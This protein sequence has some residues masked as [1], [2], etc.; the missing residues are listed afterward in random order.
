MAP[1]FFM[2]ACLRYPTEDYHVD[3]MNL[4]YF[5]LAENLEEAKISVRL[6]LDSS[7]HLVDMILSEEDSLSVEY[8]G[9]SYILDEEDSTILVMTDVSYTTTIPYSDPT[10]P[11]TL[12]F[13]RPDGQYKSE[14]YLTNDF[15][16]SVE[17]DESFTFS[18]SRSMPLD[19]R[20]TPIQNVS[21]VYIGLRD[22]DCAG[23]LSGSVENTGQSQIEVSLDEPVIHTGAIDLLCTVKVYVSGY[24]NGYA[25]DFRD[26]LVQGVQRRKS[27]IKVLYMP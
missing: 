9:D 27:H 7:P 10:K 13:D 8:D 17:N 26:A 23:Y 2:L 24:T 20:W 4:S 11:F 18:S 1:L 14:L 6:R 19:V 16:V 25:T 15:S 22:T 12:I 3:E 5:V 21:D